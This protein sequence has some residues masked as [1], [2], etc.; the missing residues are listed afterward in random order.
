[1]KDTVFQQ[2]LKPLTKELLQEC[3]RRFRSDYDC[4]KFLTWH[5]LQ[6]MI[7]AHINEIKSLSIL[8]VAINSQKIGV[9]CKVKKSTLSDA[10]QRRPAACFFWVL[11]QLMYFL[12]RKLRNNIKKVVKI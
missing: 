5:H 2:I 7:Y 4:E 12:P 10:N 1:M 8:E 11:Q 6:T 9:N 3:T